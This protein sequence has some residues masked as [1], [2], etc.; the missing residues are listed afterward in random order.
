M[1]IKDALL[2]THILLLLNACGSSTSENTDLA[3]GGI[4]G[5]GISTGPVTGFGS[6]FVNGVRF[7][8]SG[9][10]FIRDGKSIFAESDFS[11]GEYV[12]V[13]GNLNTDGLTGTA[14][15][16][17]FEDIVEGPVTSVSTNNTN[18]EVLGQK[19]VV[20]K[21]T[22]L[23]GFKLLGDLQEGN[24]LEVSGFRNAAGEINATG[25]KLKATEFID[26][27]TEL[28]VTGNIESVNA[29]AQ[30]FNLGGLTIDYSQAILEN[31]A[32]NLPS[33]GLTVE[34]K[35]T[36][37]LSSN[38]FHASFVEGK[39]SLYEAKDGTELEIEGRVT[40][41]ISSSY[42]FVGDQPVITNSTTE[43]KDGAL[44]NI[45][46]NVKIEVEGV[47]NA[48]G[49]LIA[50]SVSLR[51]SGE[52]IEIEGTVQSLDIAAG[53][54][55]VLGRQIIVNSSTIFIDESSDNNARLG[56]SD[57]VPGN[58]VEVKGNFVAGGEIL[59]TRVDRED[60]S[61]GEEGSETELEGPPENINST[62]GTFILFGVTITA[63][64]STE[65]EGDDDQEL[66]R[67]EF[68]QFISTNEG[69]QVKAQGYF[70]DGTLVAEEIEIDD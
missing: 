39:S 7:D 37:V 43:F 3:E 60:E 46:L 68:F 65:F 6:I 61:E 30:A 55:S 17:F 9:A 48:S 21:L 62:A 26:G 8:V 41:F 38:I 34:V 11:I 16:I 50:E 29:G 12:T 52:T 1:K 59:A 69:I 10:E 31:I 23:I 15:K 63:N 67:E 64:E 14:S 45:A 4:G 66:T 56:I 40:Q 20:D 42:F 25:I 22:V 36:Q 57:L 27:A 33:P 58:R 5:T 47:F 18:I 32:N 44:G 28:E 70:I 13:T 24:I 53:E 35:S 19:V 51:E 2:I 49:G 54:F